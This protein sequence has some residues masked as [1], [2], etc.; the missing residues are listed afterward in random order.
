MPYSKVIQRV[1]EAHFCP[2]GASCL[3]QLRFVKN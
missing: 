1:I 2:R 3:R